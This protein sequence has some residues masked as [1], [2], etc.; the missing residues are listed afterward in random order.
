MTDDQHVSS[1]VTVARDKLMQY[2]VSWLAKNPLQL[3]DPTLRNTAGPGWEERHSGGSAGSRQD[4]DRTH[5]IVGDY[6]NVNG[7]MRWIIGW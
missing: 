6:W 3:T 2:N 7:L 5:L 4:E 1:Y